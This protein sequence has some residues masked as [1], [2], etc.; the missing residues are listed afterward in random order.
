MTTQTQEIDGPAG[1]TAF[2][3]REHGLLID[4][5]WVAPAAAGTSDVIDPGTG[6]VLSQAASGQQADVDRAV[7]AARRSFETGHWRDK[8]AL[9][10]AAVLYDVA[11]GIKEQADELSLLEALDTGM[12]LK[13][14]RGQVQT[15]V[16][17]FRYYAGL[18][19]CALQGHTSEIAAGGQAALAYTL[20]EPV[21][22]VGLIIPWNVPL[23]M[24]AWKL[25]PALA[26]GCS[27]ILKPAEQTPLTALWL[28]DIMLAAGL[29][30]GVVNIVTGQ[31]T[32][33]GRA[34]VRHDGVDKVSFT[35]STEV[36]REIVRAA[37]G[38]LKRLTLELGGKS[39]MIVCADADLA[40]AIPALALAIFG[41]S[42]QVCSA[43]SRAIIH[44]AVHDEVVDGVAKIGRRLK[45]GYCTDRDVDLGPLIS[46]AQLDRVRSY[47]DSAR[48]EGAE[49]VSGGQVRDEPGY[50]FEPTV[51]SRTTTTMR[52]V[53]EEIFGPVLCTTSFTDLGEAIAMANDT[54][55][56]LAAS[57]FTRDVTR[58]HSVARRLRAGRVGI[59]AHA[60]AH[61]SMP[62]GGYKQSGWGRETGPD[63]IEPY[64]ETKSVFTVL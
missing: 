62:G 28:G 57:V 3:K 33:A 58:A 53:R 39:P 27:C 13:H 42:G 24:A 20:R 64:L 61:L 15:A 30:G 37:A 43:G 46:A 1:I 50:F 6:G 38:N 48:A 49:V 32:S 25:A 9:G 63:G 31:G 60:I 16:D 19:T 59:N 12:P 2:L 23:R 22:V 40:Q 26:A 10:R 52:A 5:Q 56:G 36:G 41:N 47:V 44:A 7:A 21:G 11:D 55:Y 18:L 45:L 51:L 29:G 4:G 17:C 35:G 14:A 8:D 34:I 54:D